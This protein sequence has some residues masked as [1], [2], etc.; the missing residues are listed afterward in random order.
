MYYFEIRETHSVEGVDKSA[1]LD[2]H[3][4]YAAGRCI[5]EWGVALGE[6]K[7]RKV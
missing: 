7:K 3:F 5:V 6:G 2:Q 1:L 4:G